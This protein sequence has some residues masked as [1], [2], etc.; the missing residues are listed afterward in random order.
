MN[1][2]MKQRSEPRVLKLTT[3][4][5]DKSITAEIKGKNEQDRIGA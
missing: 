1:G 2:N 5:E 4:V 3:K